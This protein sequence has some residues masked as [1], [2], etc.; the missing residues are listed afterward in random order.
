LFSSGLEK[1]IPLVVPLCA[2]VLGVLVFFI[3]SQTLE[4]LS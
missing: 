4:R 3:G 1:L 2:L